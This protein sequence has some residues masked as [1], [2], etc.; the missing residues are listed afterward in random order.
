MALILLVLITLVGIA[1]V[2]GTIMEQRMTANAYD[3][4]ISFQSAEAAMRAAQN[5]VASSPAIIARNCQAGGVVCPANPFNDS[6]LPASA[7]H[8]VAT[9]TSSGQFTVSAATEGQPQFVIENMGNWVNPTSDTGYNQ[10]ANSA[11]YDAQGKSSTAVFY[12]I[13]A[14]SGDPAVVNDRAVVV[15]QAMVKQG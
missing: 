13:T 8:T 6:N 4:A 11:Q 3:R 7:I 10:S 2:R 14:R 9:G 12:R 5:L 1:A 15:L